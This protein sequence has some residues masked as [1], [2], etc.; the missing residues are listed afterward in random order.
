MSPSKIFLVA[1]AGALVP[2][3]AQAN[4]AADPLITA[5]PSPIALDKRQGQVAG[6]PGTPILSTLKFPFTALPDQVY[7]FPVLRGPQFGFNICNSTTL[8]ANSN[9]QTLVFNSPDDFCLWGSPD[10]N[11]AIGDVEAKVVAYCTKPYHGTR[12][13][14]PG[15][16]TGLQWVRTSAYI[17][18][19]G[20][21]KNSGI[22][23][24]DTDSGGELDPHGAD[25]QGNPLG[26]VVY[27]N[28]TTDS[29]GHNLAQVF[30]W[31]TFVGGGQF[32]FKAC[33]NSVASP[34]YCEN[35]YDLI[36]C[37]YNMPNAAQDGQFLECDSDLQDPAGIFTG[38]N[39]VVSTYSMPDPL[40]APPPYQPKVPASR[41]CK[42]HAS[43]DLFLVDTGATTVASATPSGSASV[44]AG[45]SG[46]NSA[47]KP[48]AGT[49]T[50]GTTGSKS[51][52]GS[53]PS[54]TKT[55]GAQGLKVP[56][57]LLAGAALVASFL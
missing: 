33:F 45:G 32:C 53:A 41:N 34:D 8:G 39:G 13:I 23:L 14:P 25:L 11:G 31:N 5:A 3:L 56:V 1:L 50:A 43:S 54:A 36:G 22:G 17:Q 49:P 10:A 18:A 20:F 57:A 4:I 38:A 19:V 40:T 9:C 30:N 12:L 2:S 28:G 29:D 37:N 48:T 46:S 42:T 7:P 16:I 35:R 44:T 55:S 6:G 47:P 24:S 51:P 27:S 15:A 52:S 26:G 21:I